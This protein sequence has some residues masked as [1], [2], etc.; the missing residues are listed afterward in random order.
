MQTDL[1]EGVATQ[2]DFGG[3]GFGGLLRLRLIGTYVLRQSR[4]QLGDVVEFAGGI[5]PDSPLAG[6]RRARANLSLTWERE[7]L[8]L[9]GQVRF[10]GA[11]QLVNDWTSKD[12]DGNRV[13]AVACLDLRASY[14]LANHL[15]LYRAG[16]NLLN[17]DPPVLPGTADQGQNVYY[18]TATRGDLHDLVGLP[19]R[20][21]ARIRF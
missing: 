20:V 14:R 18:F 10:I 16:D 3:P 17:Q 6:I 8:S 1:A 15:E 11:A 21:G 9:T 12:V 7:R 2:L 5:G 4:E 19:Y 13:P